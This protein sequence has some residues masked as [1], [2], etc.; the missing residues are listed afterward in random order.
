M[1]PQHYTKY[2]TKQK[3]RNVRIGR[4][5][6]LWGRAHKFLIKYKIISPE[7]VDTTYIQVTLYSLS[8]LAVL[9]NLYVCNNNSFKKTDQEQCF[10]LKCS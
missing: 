6:L 10:M 3:L 2:K 4:D 5:S 7:N 9:R 8:R 1:R